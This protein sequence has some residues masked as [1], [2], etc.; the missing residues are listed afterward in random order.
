MDYPFE[1]PNCGHKEKISMRMGHVVNTGH[2]CPECN[3]EM[4]REISS[5]VCGLVI[6]KTGGFYSRIN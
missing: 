6:D 4:K 2:M 1:C 5:L 3:T